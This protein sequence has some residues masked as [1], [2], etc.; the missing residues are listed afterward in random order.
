MFRIKK[1]DIFIAKQFGLLFVGTFFICLFVLMMQF[2]WRYVDE[3][4]GKGLS[5][6]ILAQFFWYMALGLMPQAF[7]LAILLSS[8]I[9]YGNLGE[10]SELTA[11]KAAGISLMQSMRSLI[12]IVLCIAGISFYFQNVVVPSANMQLKQLLVS[13]KQK[14]PELEIPEGTFY[15]GIPNSNL[16]VEKK[17]LKTGHLYGIMIYRQT[18]SYEDQTI[19]LADSGMLQSTAE[20]KHL[21]LTL[22][23][24]EWFENMRSQDMGGTAEVPYR[25][26]SFG[27]KQILLDFDGDFNLADASNFTNDASAKSVMR[28]LHDLDSIKLSNDSIGRSFF[29]EAR[30]YTFRTEELTP[31]DSVKLQSLTAED[32]PVMDSVYAKM[33]QDKQR[34]VARQAARQAQNALSD[35]EMKSDYAKYQNR[36]ERVH[37]LEAIGKFTLALS[38]IIFFFIGAP[39]GAIIRKGG[40]GVPVIVSVIVFLVFYLLDMTGMRMARD[41]NWTVW[42]G[43][44]ISTVVL[45]PLAVFFTYKANRDSTVFNIDA[46]RLFLMRILGLRMKR[47]ITRKEVIIEEPKYR[48][49]ANMLQTIN[50]DIAIYSETHKLLRWPSPIKVFFRAGDDHEIEHINEVLETTIED[51]GYARDKHVLY[52]LNEYPIIATHAHTR[53]FEKKW[54][55]IVSGLFLPLGIFFYC[56]MIR[57]R[58]RLYRDLRDISN[59]SNKLMPIIQELA[60]KQKDKL[61]DET[62]KDYTKLEIQQNDGDIQAEQDK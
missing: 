29:E 44:S 24:G 46:Y 50:E 62:Y 32:I 30:N 9:A 47:N 45:A 23:N 16:Y 43:R 31:Q 33:N 6:E 5:M 21:L 11:I 53:P 2:L 55:N 8:L 58:L 54:L 37:L 1:L 4:I 60:D 26:E 18:G 15:D 56:R 13:M 20:K 48:M 40:L 42:F 57:F 36:L 19:I 28:I 17:D 59:T 39:L 61:L 51:L 10:S 41:D 25:R 14:S 12:F 35:V 7:P 22:W 49:D 52:T 34:E 3:L 38:C 27:H